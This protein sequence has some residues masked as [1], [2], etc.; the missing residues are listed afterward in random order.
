VHF[1]H[2]LFLRGRAGA[3]AGTLLVKDGAS[4]GQ[5]MRQRI[6]ASDLIQSVPEP[7]VLALIAIGLPFL[8]RRLRGR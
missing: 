5:V 3:Q 6:E 4:P 2:G 1:E 7:T 8:A